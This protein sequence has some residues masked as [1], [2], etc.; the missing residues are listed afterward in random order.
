MK[1]IKQFRYYHKDSSKN[2]PAS[3]VTEATM[4]SGNIFAG[5]GDISHLGIQA[6]PGTKFYLNNSYDRPIIVGFTGIYELQLNELGTIYAIKFD[7]ANLDQLYTTTV[8]CIF[9]DIIYEGSK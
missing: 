8:N 6:K 7:K 9:I 4:T 3:E 2:Y 5:H 1:Q